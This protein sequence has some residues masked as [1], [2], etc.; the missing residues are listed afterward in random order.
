MRAREADADA[1]QTRL[2]AQLGAADHVDPG[3]LHLVA[4]SA[5][6]LA[7]LD[8]KV[9]QRHARTGSASDHKGAPPSGEPMGGQKIC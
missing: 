6:A 3:L 4:D 2:F 9:R 8:V 7:A 1:P 5:A